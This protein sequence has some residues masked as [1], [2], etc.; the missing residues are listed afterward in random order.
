MF[1]VLSGFLIGGILINAR[2]ADNYFGAFYLRRACRILP[3]YAVLVAGVLSVWSVAPEAARA[4]LFSDMVPGWSYLVFAQNYFMAAAGSFGTVMLAPT[5]SVAV[6]E[7]F[8]LLLPLVVFACPPRVLPW[9]LVILTGSGVFFR[10]WLGWPKGGLLLPGVIEPLAGGILLAWAFH[11]RREWLGSR[12]ARGAALAAVCAGGAGMVA[13]LLGALAAVWR[14]LFIGLFWCGGFWLVLCGMGA[15]WTG[16]LR[17]G[18]LRG[19]GRISYGLYLL[20]LPV[21]V[22]V[23]YLA[24]PV[25]GA[26]AGAALTVAGLAVTTGLAWVSFRFMEEPLIRFGHRFNYHG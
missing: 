19:T 14:E 6:E 16:P 1:F 15:W 18:L 8:Y 5:W 3:L 24:G 9:G 2:G 11:R 10:A 23:F 21:N 12:W 13:G 26:L 25:A 4:A 20:H 7:Q 17:S 22:A